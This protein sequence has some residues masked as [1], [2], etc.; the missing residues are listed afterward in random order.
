MLL[1]LAI[2]TL[3]KPRASARRLLAIEIAP[4]TLV[5]AAAAITCIGLVLGYAGLTLSGGA[6][7]RVSAA[8]LG[9]P[10]IGA[11]LQFGV[12]AVVALLTFRIGR[13]FGGAGGFWGAVLVVVWL[14][15]ITLG[16]Q[17]VQLLALAFAPPLAGVIAIATLFW[18]LW[19]YSNF[20]AELHGFGSP[21][22]VLGVAVL[23]VIA[24]V[25]GLTMFAAI[26]GVTPQGA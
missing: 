14:N 1:Q 21:V 13:L 23:T 24:I 15:A 19:A 25:F 6:V 11:L 8:V 26:L 2:D 17:V 4:A 9:M 7:D 3:L 22:M 12:M 10:L 18:L 16:I 5:E 20:V